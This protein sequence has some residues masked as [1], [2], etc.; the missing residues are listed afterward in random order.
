MR[1]TSAATATTTIAIAGQDPGSKCSSLGDVGV[2][3]KTSKMDID[4]DEPSSSLSMEITMPDGSSNEAGADQKASVEVYNGMKN[5]DEDNQSQASAGT[6]GGDGGRSTSRKLTPP[7]R[8]NSSR[9]NRKE[10][11]AGSSYSA[12]GIITSPNE[13]DVLFGKQLFLQTIMLSSKLKPRARTQ[14]L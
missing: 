14:I 7:P 10:S 6:G 9:S 4:A 1:V 13:Y 11:G 12:E 8:Q 2:D 5:E 3:K